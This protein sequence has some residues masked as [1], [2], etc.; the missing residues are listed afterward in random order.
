M[1]DTFHIQFLVKIQ[2]IVNQKLT[3]FRQIGL[4]YHLYPFPHK[5]LTIFTE[6]TTFL[7]PHCKQNFIHREQVTI[8]FN[9]I[10]D[11]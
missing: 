11:I 5:A 4:Q 10:M 9:W 3:A 6:E 2:P 7:L 1:I 8:L